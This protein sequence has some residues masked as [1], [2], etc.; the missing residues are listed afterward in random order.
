MKTI[1]LFSGVGGMSLGFQNAGFEMISAFDNWQTAVDIYKSNFRH[2]VQRIDLSKISD[3]Q[4]FKDIKPDAIIGGPPCQDFS[5]AGK[6]NEK[7]GRADLTIAFSKIISKVKPLLFVMENVERITKS[8]TLSEAVKIFKKA[9]YG[10]T[11]KVLNASLC[12]VPQTRKRFFLIGL[13]NGK[14]NVLDYYLTKNLSNKPMSVYEYLGNEIDIEYYYR[15]PWSYGRRAVFSIYEPSPT[16]RGVNRPIPKG[17]KKHPGDAADLTENIRPLTT[18]ER[19]YIQTFP[20]GFKFK[21]TKTDLE[22]MIGNAVPVKLAEYVA[23]AILEYYSDCKQ[24]KEITMP[25]QL[26][27]NFG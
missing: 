15:H 21:G 14:D 11:S 2:D 12:G 3:C 1:D 8:Y 13:L 6:R 5:C 19:S 23:K 25:C 27:L 18:D 10:M 17:Y 7:L 26:Q 9:G 22:Q 16:I 4:I 24:N 20:K